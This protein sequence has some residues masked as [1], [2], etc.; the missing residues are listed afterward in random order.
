[1]V[2]CQAE[3]VRSWGAAHDILTR[4]EEEQ[5]EASTDSEGHDDAGASNLFGRQWEDKRALWESAKLMKKVLF[6]VSQS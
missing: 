6:F 4:F 3:D 1:M 5:M 2:H